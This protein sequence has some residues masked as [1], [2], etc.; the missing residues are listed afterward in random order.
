MPRIKSLGDNNTDLSIPTVFQSTR[1]LVRLFT[2]RDRPAVKLKGYC[3]MM[4]NSVDAR[5]PARDGTEG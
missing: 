5:C 4:V 3:G 2:E 1:M